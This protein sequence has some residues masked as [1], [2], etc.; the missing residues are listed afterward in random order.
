MRITFGNVF[1]EWQFANSIPA[2]VKLLEMSVKDNAWEEENGDT[3]IY[4]A[5]TI[6]TYHLDLSEAFIIY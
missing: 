2:E 3:N 6:R 4:H 1:Q 5:A